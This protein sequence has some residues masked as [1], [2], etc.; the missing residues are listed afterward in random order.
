MVLTPNHEAS[1][2]LVV[3]FT[4]PVVTKGYDV[5]ILKEALPAEFSDRAHVILLPFLLDLSSQYTA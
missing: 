1:H 2:E 5:T 3:I 4:Y